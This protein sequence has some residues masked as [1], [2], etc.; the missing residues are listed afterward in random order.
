M[1]RHEGP[2]RT[3]PARY[4][5]FGYDALVSGL[6]MF[7]SGVSSMAAMVV[8]G[9][10]LGRQFDGLVFMAAGNYWMTRMNLQID[11]WQVVGPRMALTLWCDSRGSSAGS[12]DREGRLA[13]GGPP[14]WKAHSK[15]QVP[16]CDL[17]G[18]MM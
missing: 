1:L 3:P 8:V 7:P 5:Q 10:L 9:I 11:F 14:T 2:K 12:R 16:A 13:Q 17:P 6:A 18:H 15:A 4:L